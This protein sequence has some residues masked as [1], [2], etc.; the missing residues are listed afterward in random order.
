MSANTET[1]QSQ[2]VNLDKAVY[3]LSYYH[4]LVFHS[5]DNSLKINVTH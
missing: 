1:S 3:V 4:V 2:N 5:E